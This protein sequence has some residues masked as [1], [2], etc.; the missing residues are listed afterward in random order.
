MLIQLVRGL[1][2]RYLGRPGAPFSPLSREDAS[3]HNALLNAVTMH[4]AGNL[5]G[6][7]AI[8]ENILLQCPDTADALHLL[9]IIEQR[10]GNLDRAEELVDRAITIVPGSVEFLNTRASVLSEL[11][12][13]EMAVDLLKNALAIEPRALRPR[14]N[15]LFMLN[16]LPGADRQKV[17]DEHRKWADIHALSTD[18][19]IAELQHPLAG[20]KLR[21]GYVSA[22]FRSHPVGR[23][24]SAVLP[25]HDRTSME[26]FCYDNTREID[27][28]NKTLRSHGD[29]WTQILDLSDGQVT[30]LIRQDGIDVLV[31]L[32]GHTHGNRLLVFANRPA[33]VQ[34]SWLGYLNTTGMTQIDWRLTC[35]ATDPE[36]EASTYHSERIWALPDCLWPWIPDDLPIDGV[37]S[38]DISHSGHVIFGSFNT[39]RKINSGVIRVWAE[40]L[41]RAPNSMLRMHGVPRGRTMD[42]LLD[43]FR[44][45]GADP[46]QIE[47]FGV[48]EHTKYQ[49]SYAQ[50]DIALDPFPYSGGAT[51]CECLWM[52]VPVIALSG[53]GSFSRSAAGIL[54][55]V[56]LNELIAAS[57]E[58]YVQCAIELSRNTARLREYR[59]TIRQRIR[60]SPIM[61]AKRFVRGLEMAYR[62][63]WE[64]RIRQ[65]EAN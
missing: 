22:D 23:I 9:S 31:D 20:R 12:K 57:Q 2:S 59:N 40:I 1:L 29:R 58:D 55:V 33:P 3:V 63:M 6:A 43:M 50:V 21:I 61:D 65:A 15:L 24:M 37:A 53:A 60:E 28:L 47:F 32:S 8:Y 48:I 17:Y 34:V 52:G 26:V 5:A 49:Q 64:E 41:R 45:G 25:C 35:V 46:A 39:F 56:G 7:A 14:S 42:D 36:P 16:L 54:S 10:K 27:S 19:R 44:D 13:V 4:R 51:T 11:G 38:P 18:K 30:D 62:S